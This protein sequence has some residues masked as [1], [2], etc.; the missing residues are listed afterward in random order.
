M[1]HTK[2]NNVTQGINLCPV[3]KFTISKKELNAIIK[4]QEKL[5]KKVISHVRQQIEHKVLLKHD[6]SNHQFLP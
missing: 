2:Y 6:L 3:M 5:H 1:N 4:K